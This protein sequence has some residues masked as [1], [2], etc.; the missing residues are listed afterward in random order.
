MTISFPIHRTWHRGPRYRLSAGTVI[1][2]VHMGS[3]TP[4][5]FYASGQLRYR[6]SDGWTD[7]YKPIVERRAAAKPASG[8]TTD[9]AKASPSPDAKRSRR[10][11]HRRRTSPVLIA[12]LSGLVGFGLGGGLLNADAF[13]GWA[14]WASQKASETYAMVSPQ[15]PPAKAK[16]AATSPQPVAAKTAPVRRDAKGFVVGGPAAAKRPAD[17]ENPS[18]SDCRK[19]LD[20]VRAWSDYQNAHRPAGSASL[21]PSSSDKQYLATVCG[22]TF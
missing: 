13:R 15:T 22:L 14:D 9:Q 10:R 3:D 19:Y 11:T 12:M 18:Q 8:E 2:E 20:Q 4:G 1:W 16:A 6:D 5:W 21:L 7:Q 17:D